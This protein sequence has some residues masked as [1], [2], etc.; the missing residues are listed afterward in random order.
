MKRVKV[1]K[2]FIIHHLCDSASFSSLSKARTWL[3]E[4]PEHKPCPT[5]WFKG[6]TGEDE[7]ADEGGD[8]ED[9]G[10]EDKVAGTDEG[11]ESVKVEKTV[12]D[13]DVAKDKTEK[14]R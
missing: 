4:N 5:L 12:E 8:Q 2:K 1:E 13:E 11:I 3:T 14:S 10:G 9:S 6:N 7:E